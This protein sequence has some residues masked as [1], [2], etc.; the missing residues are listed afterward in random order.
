MSLRFAALLT[1][2]EKSLHDIRALQAEVE[3]MLEMKNRK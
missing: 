1:Q 3:V 2:D